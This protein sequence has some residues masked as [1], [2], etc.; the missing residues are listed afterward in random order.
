[1]VEGGGVEE[2]VEEEGG[3]HTKIWYLRYSLCYVMHSLLYYSL[4]ARPFVGSNT[5][6]HGVFRAISVFSP[7]P[8]SESVRP[9]EVRANPHPPPI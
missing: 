8:L 7:P 5:D 9:R 4:D 1:M 6:S 2:E 3:F